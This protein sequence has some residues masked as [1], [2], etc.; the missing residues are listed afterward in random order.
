[1]DS[2]PAVLN[3]FRYMIASYLDCLIEIG[4]RTRDLEKPVVRAR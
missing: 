2:T 1:M 4:N 3:R